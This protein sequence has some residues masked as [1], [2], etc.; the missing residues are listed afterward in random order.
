MAGRSGAS[1]T[2]GP[3]GAG[4]GHRSPTAPGGT[5]GRRGAIQ[6]C[7]RAARGYRRSRPSPSGARGAGPVEPHGLTAGRGPVPTYQPATGLRPVRSP[8]STLRT[9]SWSGTVTGSIR[10]ARRRAG[11]P[12]R[13]S[14]VPGGRSTGALGNQDS[15]RGRSGARGRGRR[16]RSLRPAPV[17]GGASSP[18]SRMP[19][20]IGR[21]AGSAGCRSRP[22]ARPGSRGRARPGRPSWGRVGTFVHRGAVGNLE[23]AGRSGCNPAGAYGGWARAGGRPLAGPVGRMGI[24]SLP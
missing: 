20:G 23:P 6:G 17:G 5:I 7:G 19:E 9:A 24:G 14:W 13:T 18:G 16:G 21:T 4:A 15:G 12:A 3:G 1:A 11:A 10:P 2:S 22:R 8:E